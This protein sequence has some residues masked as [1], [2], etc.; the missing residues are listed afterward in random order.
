MLWK[1]KSFSFAPIYQSQEI[2]IL[3]KRYTQVML[4]ST[5][6][7]IIT[8]CFKVK[9]TQYEGST[10]GAQHSLRSSVRL[11]GEESLKFPCVVKGSIKSGPNQWACT[12][13]FGD[14]LRKETQNPR[15]HRSHDTKTSSHHCWLREQKKKGK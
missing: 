3:L 8:N 11:W 6:C 9:F 7:K 13:G 1:L 2:H 15:L 5:S 10:Q 12:N 14:N 4:L